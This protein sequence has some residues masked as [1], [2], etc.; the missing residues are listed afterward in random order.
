MYDDELTWEQFLNYKSFKGTMGTLVEVTDA[1]Y[2][3]KMIANE[4][5][6]GIEDCKNF[7]EVQQLIDS[8]KL[9]YVE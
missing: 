5:I 3:C 6:K 7:H 9:T 1:K 2:A 8:L 4:I